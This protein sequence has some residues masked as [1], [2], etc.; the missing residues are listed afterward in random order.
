MLINKNSADVERVLLPKIAGSLNLWALDSLIQPGFVCHFS[1]LSGLVGNVGQADYAA[2]NGYID[3]LTDFVSRQTP[4]GRAH[5]QSVNWGL[6]ASEGMQMAE[7]SSELLALSDEQG[8]AALRTILDQAAPR[9]VAFAGSR[10]L[11]GALNPSG[12]GQGVADSP[13]AVSLPPEPG[14]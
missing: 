6:W 1:S 5:W 10:A 12:G 7:G 11:L 4:A 2:A 8:L 3:E 9:L 14:Q 13:A